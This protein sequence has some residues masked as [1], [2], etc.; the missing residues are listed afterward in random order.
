ML[1]LGMSSFLL[2]ATDFSKSKHMKPVLWIYCT[3][4]RVLSKTE[5]SEASLQEHFHFCS[6]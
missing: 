5:I 6:C 1:G 4:S 2:D 3:L